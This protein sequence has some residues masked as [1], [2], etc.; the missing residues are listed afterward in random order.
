M[1]YKN[2]GDTNSTIPC[3]ANLEHSK[4]LHNLVNTATTT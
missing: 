4:L 2:T 1:N 3:N